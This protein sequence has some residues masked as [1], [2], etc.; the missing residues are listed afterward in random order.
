M[1]RAAEGDTVP[2]SEITKRREDTDLVHHDKWVERGGQR[3]SGRA[4]PD[5]STE[6]LTTGIERLYSDPARFYE[7]DPEFSEFVVATL[8]GWQAEIAMETKTIVRI[9]NYIAE[10]TPLGW[11][12]D[13]PKTASFCDYAFYAG[14]ISPPWYPNRRGSFAEQLL[15]VCRNEN[16]DTEIISIGGSDAKILRS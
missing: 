4:C 7:Q 5:G 14:G 11:R 6:I 1:K 16:I 2:L 12:S 10:W 3:Y 15:A 8:R 9:G 13:N